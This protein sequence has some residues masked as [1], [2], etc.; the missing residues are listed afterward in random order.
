[1]GAVR[2]ERTDVREI[3]SMIIEFLLDDG[4]AK[5]LTTIHAYVSRKLRRGAKGRIHQHLNSMLKE[6]IIKKR[7]QESHTPK[8]KYYREVHYFLNDETPYSV[9]KIFNYTRDLKFEIVKKLM[10]SSWY[11]RAVERIVIGYSFLVNRSVVPEDEKSTQTFAERSK[12]Y[13][14][15][16]FATILRMSD[17]Q[18]V[19]FK[20][21]KE[22]RNKITEELSGVGIEIEMANE[23]DILEDAFKLVMG[24]SKKPVPLVNM[25]FLEFYGPVLQKFLLT[26]PESAKLFFD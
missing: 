12:K 25:L 17:L 4:G 11:R 20:F 23:T 21:S 6:G 10:K 19:K 7:I 26:F 1:M 24:K 3:K 13:G 22:Q 14:M 15:G 8:G 9:A 16:F 2:G 18:H 5:T